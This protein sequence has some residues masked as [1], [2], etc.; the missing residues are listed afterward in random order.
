MIDEVEENKVR[1]YNIKL[2]HKT[3]LVVEIVIIQTQKPIN[4]YQIQFILLKSY[5]MGWKYDSETVNMNIYNI[6]IMHY[7]WNMRK[8]KWPN[9]IP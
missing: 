3:I 9:E 6:R 1:E 8:M 7:Q 2:E 4:S 5:L